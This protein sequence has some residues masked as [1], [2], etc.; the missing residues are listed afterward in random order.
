MT[1]IFDPEKRSEIMSKVK[2]KD[3]APELML[4]RALWEAG[5]RYRKHYGPHRIDIAFPC[6]KVAIFVDGCF[7]HGCPLH[8]STPK[9]NADYWIPK[10]EMNKRRDRET[11]AALEDEGWIVIRVWEH[12]LKSPESMIESIKQVIVRQAQR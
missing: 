12:E 10:L 7:W 1:D 8:A 4:R 5:L 11:T 6:K 2:G 3:T 9:T